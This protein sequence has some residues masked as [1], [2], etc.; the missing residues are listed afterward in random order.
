V[1]YCIEAPPR[2]G[3]RAAVHRRARGRLSPGSRYWSTAA[4]IAESV[5]LRLLCDRLLEEGSVRLSY[6]DILLS[7]VVE[8][9]RRLPDL[10]GVRSGSGCSVRFRR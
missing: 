6:P 2:R 9:E 4:P 1:K 3:N 8:E 5:W 10:R 7:R